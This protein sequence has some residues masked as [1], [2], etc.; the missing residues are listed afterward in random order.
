M[1]K[2]IL[3]NFQA[4]GDILML[5]AAVRDLHQGYPNQFLTDV[6]TS[7]P[8]LWQ[9][10]PY[11][12]P[13]NH[14]DPGVESLRCE[15]PLI[16]QS[17]RR[18]AHFL[19]GFIDFLN[20]Q[21]NL[22]I[23][24]TQFKGDLHLS[25]LEKAAPSVVE[26]L[27]GLD[28]PYWVIVA[29]G[30]YDFTIKWWHFRRWQSV[31]DHFK[32]RIVF[33]QV[34]KTDDYHPSLH[35]VIDLRNKTGLRRLVHLV[36][37]AQGVLCPVTCL[38]HLAAAVECRP[39]R[40]KTRPCVVVAG[41]REPPHWEAYPTHQF[42]HTVG[43]LR[44]CAESGCWRSRIVPLGDGDEKDGENHLCVD[45]VNGLPHCMDMITPEQI[46]ERIRCYFDGG[47]AKY[48]QKDQWRAISA[49]LRQDDKHFLTDLRE[50]T[51]K[52]PQ[53]RRVTELRPGQGTVRTSA[54]R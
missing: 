49:S 52:K 28:V 8:E 11:L 14:K 25:E 2:L 1:R 17:D 48:L 32:K 47:Q 37:H 10:N 26:Q 21:L 46:I 22:Q 43:A 3:S 53:H 33:V 24:P 42:V 44:C 36:Y 19:H 23:Q 29:G 34:G 27:T 9:N 13:L 35:D 6:R 5:T 54:K 51:N 16:H 4:P 41:G 45:V 20:H 31:V 30:K 15:Y 40:S 7:Y 12:T 50:S 39:D 18:A 38:M